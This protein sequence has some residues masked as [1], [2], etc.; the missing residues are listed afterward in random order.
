MYNSINS[1]ISSF[2]LIVIYKK[3]ILLER[4]KRQ[5]TIIEQKFIGENPLIRV[6]SFVD[7]IERRKFSL[8]KRNFAEYQ[9]T[10]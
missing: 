8:S 3:K 2:R 9:I 10:L 7:R 1:S 4:L 6:Q 5:V